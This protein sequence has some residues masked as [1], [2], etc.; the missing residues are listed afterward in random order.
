MS[1]PIDYPTWKIRGTPTPNEK[2]VVCDECGNADWTIHGLGPTICHRRHAHASGKE[3]RMR[4]ATADEYKIGKAA[5][6]QVI[7]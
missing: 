6:T 1:A 5:I 3:R 4:E 7:G 2:L